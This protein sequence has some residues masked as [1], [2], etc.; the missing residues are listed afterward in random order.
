MISPSTSNCGKGTSQSALRDT[1]PIENVKYGG[2]NDEDKVSERQAANRTRFAP[3]T[4]KAEPKEMVR[5][6]CPGCL[7]FF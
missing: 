6:L 3:R 2:F 5:V 7:L 4:I 1:S